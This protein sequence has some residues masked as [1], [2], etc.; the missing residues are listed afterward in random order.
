MIE[1]HSS[2]LIWCRVSNDSRKYEPMLI[3]VRET[4]PLE[5]KL[6]ITMPGSCFMVV[7]A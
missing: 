5:G 6:S 1:Q 7:A 3:I 2:S 4:Q